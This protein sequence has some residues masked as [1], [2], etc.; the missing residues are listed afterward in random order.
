VRFLLDS[1]AES[2]LV[3]VPAAHRIGATIYPNTKQRPSQADGISPMDVRGEIHIILTG[4]N[5]QF[6][7]DALVVEKLGTSAIAGTPFLYDHDISIHFRRECIS[8]GDGKEIEFTDAPPTPQAR[9][10]TRMVTTGGICTL[11]KGNLVRGSSKATTV[12][13]GEC[14]QAPAPEDC[15]PGGLCLIEPR[16]DNK[17]SVGTGDSGIWPQPEAIRNVNGFIAIPNNTK[18]PIVVKPNSHICSLVK[19][20]Y[21]NKNSSVLHSSYSTNKRQ[22]NRPKVAQAQSSLHS[23]TVKVDPSKLL[24]DRDRSELLNLCREFDQIF[25][26]CYKG[27]N[28]ASGHFTTK[29]NMGPTFPPQRKG[30]IPQYNQDRLVILQEK[31]DE[32]ERLGVFTRPEDVGV[33]VEYANPSFLVK[34]SN[35]SHRLVT[36]F[37]EVGRYA[38]PTP[39]LL[40]DVNSTLRKI[41]QWKYI[42]ITDLN[43]SYYQIPLDKASMKYCGVATPFKGMRVYTTAAMG[44]PGSES[45]LEEL[46]SLVLGDMIMAGKV[47]KIADD[48]Y[49]GGD[50]PRELIEN[51]R[52]LF[53][54]LSKNRLSISAHKTVLVP[55]SATVLGWIWSKG[56]LSA[57]P[58]VINTLTTCATPATISA[59][60]SFVGSVKALSKVLPSCAA[61]VGPL[62]DVISAHKPGD[63]LIWTET[64]E[65]AF[66]QCQKSLSGCKD[67]HLPRQSDKLWLVTDA[68]T[69]VQGLGATLY[70]ERQGQIRPAG[71]YSAKLRRHQHNWL[72]CELEALALATATKH[73]SPFI[74]QSNQRVTIL[75]DSRP[76]VQAYAKMRKGA[77]SASPRVSTFLSVLSQYQVDLLHIAGHSNLHS[78]FQSRN[79]PI[80]TSDS[81]QICKF[82]SSLQES[83]VINAIGARP[84]AGIF[85]NRGAWKPIQ[86]ECKDI[87]RAK[88]HLHQGTRPSR[89]VTNAKDVKRY[90]QMCVIGDDGLLVVKSD[91]PFKRSQHL[92]VVPRQVLAGILTAI[93]LQMEH[94]TCAQLKSIFKRHF[95]A[96]DLDKTALTVSNS[97]HQCAALKTMPKMLK[98]QS[99]EF[100]PT[101][102]GISFAADIM[103]AHRQYILVIRE[104]I[105][106][107]T[108][109]SLISSETT[110]DIKTG[111]IGLLGDSTPLAGPPAVLRTDAG[112][113][114]V[115]LANDCD[116]RE[117]NLVIDIGERKNVN[118][119]PVGERAVQE[120]HSE[121]SKKDPHRNPITST[122]LALATR[123]L[124][125]KIR[126]RGLS[127][128]EMWLQRDQFDFSQIPV[129]DAKLIEDQAVARETN[130]GPSAKNK[131]GPNAKPNI[132]SIEIGDLVYVWSDRSKTKPRDRYLVVSK[133]GPW[134]R[135]QKFIGNQLR[136]RS[137]KVRLSDCFK[138]P[139]FENDTFTVPPDFNNNDQ[140]SVQDD[141]E[142]TSSARERADRAPNTDPPPP[143]PQE[144][145]VPTDSGKYDNQ[146]N[147]IPDNGP[148]PGPDQDPV[149][150]P[151]QMDVPSSQDSY[152]GARGQADTVPVPVEPRSSV[153]VQAK[154]VTNGLRRSSRRRDVPKHF[155]DFV[156]YHTRYKYFHY[157]D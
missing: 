6:K 2:N 155:K 18:S 33:T 139:S 84:A 135:V 88:A 65:T 20:T 10:C 66:R 95:F 134:C 44:M 86:A 72:P 68:A 79:P 19:G 124:N 70:V 38:K 9:P 96:L 25:D 28:G 122:T 128:R 115:S 149:P 80:C 113:G 8:L 138:I 54:R 61:I 136:A 120:L 130:R 114:F 34:K 103:R 32:L 27:Y 117:I 110:K 147:L 26:P 69:S 81:C 60:R 52:E 76:C 15:P 119:N 145:I 73:F 78:D 90:L 39:S 101:S 50:T 102:P 4:H 100:A 83:V 107:F 127:A 140:L 37:N 144:L 71:F 133:N 12:W 43:S 123:S 14:Y 146:D 75:T 104:T 118:K 121:L 111:T 157:Y 106:S 63:K 82:A 49:C 108:W 16:Y 22:P 153:P 156:V 85:S 58:H 132:V 99:S 3:D 23:A 129:T 92:I 116:L 67:I 125:S 137:Y 94:P 31:F 112:S 35:G 56:T 109:T 105:T 36:A 53:S 98:E 131:A 7:F 30:R 97:C 5:C 17:L 64:A 93:H 55:A 126:S 154:D 21:C 29:N 142:A 150:E 46:M 91:T 1:G 87:R 148:I 51:T 152:Q 143:I 47:A 42:I 89:K 24:N 77:F 45:A 40:P 59:L 41:A 141:M 13:P 57:S 151:V 74:I 11:S 48:L 62:D